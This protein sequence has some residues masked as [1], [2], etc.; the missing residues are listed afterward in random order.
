MRYV[1][2]AF[3]GVALGAIWLNSS[4]SG[5]HLQQKLMAHPQEPG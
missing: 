2:L 4:V 1:L 3:V 5:H